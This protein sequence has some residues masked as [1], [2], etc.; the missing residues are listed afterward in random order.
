MPIPKGIIWLKWDDT[1]G[2]LVDWQYPQIFNMSI[3]ELLAIYTSQTM[4]NTAIPR[5][6]IYATDGLQIASYFGGEIHK[7]MAILI[8]NEDEDPKLFKDKLIQFYHLVINGQ[9]NKNSLESRIQD[10]FNIVEEH[11]QENQA[12]L[13]SIEKRFDTY[14]EIF[15]DFIEILDKRM[16]KLENHILELTTTCHKCDRNDH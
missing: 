4:G 6:A 3:N 14:L 7:D 13:S 9:V 5:F 2:I 1:M 10:L 12:R 16:K 11:H 15:K 8:L